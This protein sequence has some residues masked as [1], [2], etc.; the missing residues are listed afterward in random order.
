VI[1]RDGKRFAPSYGAVT[2]SAQMARCVPTLAPT[3]NSISR[4][5][6]RERIV[7][8]AIY[9]HEGTCAFDLPVVDKAGLQV[10]LGSFTCI[11]R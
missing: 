7:A 4:T 10:D 9:A 1:Q 6:G 3:A 5:F 11:E 2:S 8:T